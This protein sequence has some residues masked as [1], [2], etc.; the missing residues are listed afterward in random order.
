M[1]SPSTIFYTNYMMN[2]EHMIFNSSERL[3]GRTYL[4]AIL[5]SLIYKKPILLSKSGSSMHIEQLKSCYIFFAMIGK[6]PETVFK[7]YLEEHNGR[8]KISGESRVWLTQ[9]ACVNEESQ[10]KNLLLDIIPFLDQG[11]LCEELYELYNN[12]KRRRQIKLDLPLSSVPMLRQ[13]ADEF[14]DLNFNLD[15]YSLSFMFHFS[16]VRKKRPVRDLEDEDL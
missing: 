1:K 16:R 5:P 10:A 7:P 8:S 12:P 11:K 15:D 6:N 9:L 13:M 3:Y 2:L 14:D 4:S